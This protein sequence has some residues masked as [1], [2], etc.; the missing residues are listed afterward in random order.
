MCKMREF[1]ALTPRDI[2][3]AAQALTSAQLDEIATQKRGLLGRS[4]IPGQPGD[5]EILR[6]PGLGDW[7]VWVTDDGSVYLRPLRER[8]MTLVREAAI[9]SLVAAGLTAEEADAA[10][11]ADP[12]RFAGCSKAGAVNY[13]G[14]L[15]VAGVKMEQLLAF[16]GEGPRRGM[17]EWFL[18]FPEL[19]SLKPAGRPYDPRRTLGAA[20]AARIARGGR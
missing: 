19:K 12:E 18:R 7:G 3:L 16:T 5:G 20:C 15:L 10:Y 8:T 6:S 2:I 17:E 13:L 4:T 14:D 11:H 1:R 9:A